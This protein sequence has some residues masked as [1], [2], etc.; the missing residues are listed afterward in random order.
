M[1][2]MCDT[3]NVKQNENKD[4]GWATSFH[5]RRPASHKLT[6]PYVFEIIDQNKMLGYS[7]QNFLLAA[8]HRLFEPGP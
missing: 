8:A 5:R 3:Q 1:A 4:D 7:R 6:L 2:A